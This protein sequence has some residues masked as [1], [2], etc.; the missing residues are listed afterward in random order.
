MATLP[1]VVSKS[2]ERSVMKA[3]L[4]AFAVLVA[5][6]TLTSVAVAAPEAAKQRVAITS[7]GE[8][9]ATAFGEFVFTPLQAGALQR[10]TGTE[11]S[12]WSE[13]V[14]MRDGQQVTVQNYVT[15]RK[16]KR[17]SFVVRSRMEYVDA[18]NGYLVGTNTW[19]FV[20]GTGQYAQITCGGRGGDVVVSGRWS[21][22]Y[23]GLLTN[24]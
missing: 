24:S 14:V 11:T 5:A 10:D 21:D 2:D 7:S 4:A 22:R 9:N 17:G 16:G 12:R 3:K 13:R 18:G 6:V 15:T 19:K 1:D 20:R 8:L 23:E